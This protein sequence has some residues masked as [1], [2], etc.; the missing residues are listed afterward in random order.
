MKTPFVLCALAIA[1]G[2][3]AQVITIDQAKALAGNVTPGDGP[4]FPVTLSQPGSYRLTSNL[5]VADMAASGIVISSPGVTLDL[6]GFELRGPNVCSGQAWV[7]ACTA[8]PL[9][10]TARGSGV[11]VDLPAGSPTSV[12]I[13]NGT[14]RGFASYGVRA[15][16]GGLHAYTVDRLLI[17][18]SGHAGLNHAAAVTRSVIDRNRT[19]GIHHSFSVIGNTISRNGSFPLWSSYIRHNSLV[20]NGAAPNSNSLID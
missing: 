3:Q 11:L 12:A 16:N 20:S 6:G 15:V 10:A 7:T 2:A 19:V 17:S 13:G 5:V 8:D 14:L 18:H 1:A 4:G 9:A